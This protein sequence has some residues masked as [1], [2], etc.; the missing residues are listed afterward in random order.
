MEL[1]KN[2]VNDSIVTC[3][4][5]FARSKS[6][7]SLIN[8]K[9]RASKY[10]DERHGRTTTANDGDFFLSKTRV[11]RRA[12]ART[13]YEFADGALDTRLRGRHGK[14]RRG[15]SRLPPKTIGGNRWGFRG[16]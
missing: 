14:R 11:L 9:K 16:A 5:V 2:F 10:D 15:F 4:V 7:S 8:K 1:V 12:Y 3:I 6:S 13:S